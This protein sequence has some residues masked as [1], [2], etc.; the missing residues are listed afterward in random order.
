MSRTI[1]RA[2][3]TRRARLAAL[4]LAVLA[5]GAVVATTSYAAFSST[6]SNDDNGWETGSIRLTDDDSGAALFRVSGVQPGDTGTRCITVTSTGS[7]PSQVRLYGAGASDTNGLASHLVLSVE[8]GTGSTTPSCT[9]FTAASTGGNLTTGTLADF[10]ADHTSWDTG[11]PTWSPTGAATESR[12]FRVTWKL[13]TEA[14][15]TVQES[16]A[17]VDLVWEARSGEGRV[18]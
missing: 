15:N 9:G 2:R 10:T 7:L 12:S 8:Q 1:R 6:T 14:P 5:A 17:D 4:P 18:R 13:E 3:W 11:L 16:R